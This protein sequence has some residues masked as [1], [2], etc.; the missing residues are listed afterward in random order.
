MKKVVVAMD[1]FKGSLSSEE[2][3]EAVKKGVLSVFPDCNVLQFPVADGGEGV[4]EVLVSAMRGEYISV[5]VHNPLME[6]IETR[7]GISGDGKTALIEM[8]LVNGLTLIPIFERNPMQTT[9]FGLGEL[10]KNALDRGC[11]D[12]IIGIGG[13]ATNDAGL[14][15]LQALGFHFFDKNGKELGMGGKIMPE[16]TS[17]DLS[18][19]H[20][21]LKHACFTIAC[22][23]NNPFCGPNGAT[24]VF[25]PQKGA[26]ANM[27]QKLDSGMFSLSK[28]IAETTGQNIIDY[29]G[30]GAA[31]GIG[32]V[33]R[34]FLNAILKP[35]IQLLLDKLDFM[36]KIK[37]A[38][39]IITGEGKVDKQ[40][41]MGKVPFGILE[42]AKKQNIPVVVI[43]G[44]M[45]DTAVLNEAGFKAI[46]SITPG[47]VSLEEITMPNTAKA[48]VFRLSSQ[49]CSVISLFNK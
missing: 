16:V 26:D 44:S 45:E 35:G 24:Y 12:F 39:L 15:M 14:G 13:S 40:T 18:L 3:G 37:D 17:I 25:A 31:G 10:V 34:A 7:Y 41:L 20:P 46:F 11:R 6:L 30:A 4:L 21:A 36:E 23:V 27:L 33:F 9:S 29:P 48:N 22:D 28:V 38:D 2:A 1:S 19:A 47:P 32:G 49:I 43:A 5:H 8:A 42:E